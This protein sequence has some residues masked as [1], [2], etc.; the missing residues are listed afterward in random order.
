[1]A[2]VFSLVMFSA[3][4]IQP[5]LVFYTY[6]KLGYNLDAATAFTA[7]ALFNLMRFPMAFLPFGIV[8]YLNMRVS[9]ARISKFLSLPEC[10]QYVTDDV[11]A[12]GGA[13]G[14]AVVVANGTFAWELAPSAAEKEQMAA[15]TA[16][17]GRRSA[18]DR[19]RKEGV[20]KADVELEMVQAEESK[21]AALS[22]AA[23]GAAL[24][25]AEA[26]ATVEAAEADAHAV[27]AGGAPPGTM[28]CLRDVSLRVKKGS[29]TAVVGA[30]GSGKSSLV[31]ALMGG[32]ERI[33]TEH[34]KATVAVADKASVAYAAQVPWIL[35]RTLR[36]NVEFGASEGKPKGWFDDVV[37][38]CALKADIAQLPGGEASE[39]GE[40][41]I[42]L[43]GGQKARVALARAVYADAEL[44][45]EKRTLLLRL[46]AAA[47]HATTATAAATTTTTTT[48]TT[49]PPRLPGTFWTTR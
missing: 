1:M 24:N 25:E 26:A 3:P 12:A 29:L 6:I 44:C 28:L 9:S 15:E 16:R 14:D 8:Q 19:Q 46:H 43:S 31:A 38:A 45:V 21:N 7:I 32:L 17:R 40:R 33:G 37:A 47:R 48:T 42:N 5:I 27:E 10:E 34:T 23:D 41:G 13:D 36:E 22:A 39:I 49:H 30:V 35:N 11:A 4:I 20:S 2:S 18:R